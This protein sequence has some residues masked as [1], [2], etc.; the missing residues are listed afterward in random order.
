MTTS[1]RI[2]VHMR[3][4]WSS[5][6][7][8]PLSGCARELRI[9]TIAPFLRKAK[10]ATE[11]WNNPYQSWTPQFWG[12]PP[13]APFWILNPN[14]SH[15]PQCSKMPWFHPVFWGLFLDL[16]KKIHLIISLAKL[17]F[18][19]SV[20]TCAYFKQGHNPARTKQANWIHCKQTP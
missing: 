7:M 15:F 12:R 3:I 17:H 11:R 19:V 20:F 6:S 18:L 4:L 14:V 13:P 1:M 9:A 8:F 16:P 10:K 5:Q 2:F